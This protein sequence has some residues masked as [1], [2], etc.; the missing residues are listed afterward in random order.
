MAERNHSP[1]P[2]LWDKHQ[3]AQHLGVTPDSARRILNRLGIP[4][5]Q[6]L[7]DNH[8]RAIAYWRADD[9]RKHRPTTTT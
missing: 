2:E 5:A 4:V 9:I 6:R 1:T 8:G 7:T 3:A